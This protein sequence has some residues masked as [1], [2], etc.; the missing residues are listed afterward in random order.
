MKKVKV[1]L[2]IVGAIFAGLA[3]ILTTPKVYADDQACETAEFYDPLIC[4]GEYPDEELELIRRVRDTLNVVYLWVGIIAVIVII[5]AGINFMISRGQADKVKRARDAILYAVI[6]LI[7]TLA[8][9]AITGL[10]I[11]ALEGQAVSKY[12]GGG[13]GSGGSGGGGNSP[14]GDDRKEVR[15]IAV[16]AK[17][18]TLHPGNEYTLKTKVIPNYATDKTIKYSIDKPGIASIEQS[19]VIR[20]KK[21]GEAIVTIS[22]PSGIEKTVKIHVLKPI[23]VE[24]I[25][26]SKNE[27]T[28]KK[29][30]TTTVTATPVPTNAADK[31]IIWKSKNSKIAT[32]S[33]YGTI[34]AIDYGNTGVV[35]IARN[36]P[37]FAYESPNKITLAATQ[38]TAELPTVE[39]EVKVKVGSDH[40]ACTNSTANTAYKGNLKLRKISMDLLTPHLK[41]F[42]WSNE[43]TVINSKGGYTN[44]I[45]SLGG[46]Y[47]MY[48]GNDKKIN[49]KSACDWQVAAEYT[50]GL[51]TLWGT[52][53]DNGDYYG[54]WGQDTNDQSDAFWQGWPGRGHAGSGYGSRSID[55][56][57]TD[58]EQKR[59][60]KDDVKSSFRR[61]FFCACGAGLLSSGRSFTGEGFHLRGHQSLLA[62]G[63]VAVDHAF[64]D[65]LVKQGLGLVESGHGSLS[66]ALLDD[67][68]DLFQSGLAA[69][70][71]ETVVQTVS[72]RRADALDSGLF[73]G[74][75]TSP[76]PVKHSIFYHGQ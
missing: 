41:D 52:D 35:A 11:N 73:I 66:L 25:K 12:S 3:T 60:R 6:G 62:G 5:I 31:T 65:G 15:D 2:L 64:D 24:R 51:F 27:V 67:G 69:A 59:R 36:Q 39:A 8:A 17:E 45:K 21:E 22:T 23:A 44:Y 55:E 1:W 49:I 29:N 43:S 37:V 33:Q 54:L 46:I 57:L 28:L 30:Q 18:V 71:P 26:L 20:G 38:V 16:N 72:L 9:F 74:H 50:F 48:A 63:R 70:L 13:G 14:F 76:P 61:L 34:K 53:Y 42:T 32:V 10:V 68:Q 19:G 75:C 47:T 56:N 58:S 4:G 7:V 40:Y